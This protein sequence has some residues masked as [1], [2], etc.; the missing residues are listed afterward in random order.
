MDWQYGTGGSA[1]CRLTQLDEPLCQPRL[2]KNNFMSPSVWAR[3]WW[4]MV[5]GKKKLNTSFIVHMEYEIARLV[6]RWR[7]MINSITAAE[8]TDYFSNNILAVEEAPWRKVFFFYPT[9]SAGRGGHESFF[10]SSWA[11][12]RVCD[13]TSRCVK[14]RADTVEWAGPTT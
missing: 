2:V 12:T 13:D 1:L 7:A 5:Y 9:R 4:Q 14:C 3:A 11:K 10:S 8:C 6:T